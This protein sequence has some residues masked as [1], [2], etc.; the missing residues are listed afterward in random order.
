[1]E[2][3]R[4]GVESG[5][6]LSVYATATATWDLSC[7]CNLHHC[8]RQRQILNPL[9][10]ARDGICILMVPSEVHFYGAMTGTPK[11]GSFKN[12]YSRLWSQPAWVQIP[13]SVT[14]GQ[15][16]HLCDPKLTLS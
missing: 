8:S 11:I 13:D 1:M 6:Q 9:S 7:I 14:W 15:I 16:L 2:V 10:E 3:P 4:L 12:K 5:L